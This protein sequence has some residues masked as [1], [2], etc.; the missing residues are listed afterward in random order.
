MFDVAVLGGGPGG[1][2]AA[3]RAAQLGAKVALIEKNQIG[4]TCLNRGC[5]PTKAL[6]GSTS[7]LK[8]LKH[9]EEFGLKAENVSF[10]REAIANRAKKVVDSLRTGLGNVIKSHGI[11]VIEG[12][13]TFLEPGKISVDGKIVEAKE[14]ILATGSE[15]ARFIPGIDGERIF[16]S[17]E[18]LHL[19]SIPERLA[20]VGSG[21]IGLEFA[22]IYHELGAKILMIEAFERLAPAVDAELSNSLKRTLKKK[23]YELLLGTKVESIEKGETLTLKLSDGTSVEADAV[24][25]AIGRKPNTEGFAEKGLLLDQRGYVQ[26]DNHMA[27][28]LPHVWAIGDIVGKWMLAH[29]ASHQ[30]IVAVETALGHEA[31]MSYDAVPSCI[32]C[33]PEIAQVGITEEE[34]KIRGLSYKVGRFP[35]A[36]CGKAVADGETDGMLKTIVEEKNGK[37]LGVHILGPHASALIQEGVL[38]LDY[39]HTAEE[40]L[41]SIH[42]HPALG[43]AMME[44]VATALERSTALPKPRQRVAR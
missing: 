23:G 37:L 35:F 11:E 39:K 27:T 17:D 43:E 36:A 44:S 22:E 18:A 26:V 38:A 25:V 6:L 41:E 19:A 4:G 20:I 28:N 24:L 15:V 21:A 31:L 16:T 42:A 9:A 34:A 7:R 1:Y 29:V 8:T 14:I 3:I 33:D 2:V 32:Y 5:I 13:G 40:I 30:G 10:D 12:E